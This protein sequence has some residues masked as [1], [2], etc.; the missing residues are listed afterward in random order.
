MF[1]RTG[2]R[3]V[4]D[5][6][7]STNKL[8]ELY[9]TACRFLEKTKKANTRTFTDQVVRYENQ[10]IM[11]Q[12]QYDDNGYNSLEK[13]T[14]VAY[15]E[16]P[17][18]GP[19]ILKPEAIISYKPGVKLNWEHRGGVSDFWIE[20]VEKALNQLADQAEKE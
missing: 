20:G 15:T 13:L 18:T 9:V 6:G 14:I 16:K 2:E 12:S 4:Y 10:F 7:V 11:F 1:P 3:K 17:S 19:K 8:E 5:E